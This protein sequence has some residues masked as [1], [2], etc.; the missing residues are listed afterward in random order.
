MK[1]GLLLNV[2]VGESPAIL[3]LLAGEDQPLLVRRNALL[4]LDLGLDI[5]DRVGRLNLKRDGLPSQSLD[6]DLHTSA[7]TED[8]KD[9]ETGPPTTQQSVCLPRCNVDSF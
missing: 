5:V 9:G 1:S 6:K 7:K 2:V 8:F 4:V 3:E